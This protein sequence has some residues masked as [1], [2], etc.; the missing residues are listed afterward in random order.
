MVISP[1]H[2]A[3]RLLSSQHSQ[4]SGRA[5]AVAEQATSTRSSRTGQKT[6]RCQQNSVWHPRPCLH[7]CIIHAASRAVLDVIAISS[8]AP[9]SDACS[10]REMPG[11]VHLAADC[12]TSASMHAI[13]ADPTFATTA[14]CGVLAS[15]RPF[16]NLTYSPGG[17]AWRMLHSGRLSLCAP[18]GGQQALLSSTQLRCSFA[19]A[20]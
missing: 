7:T 1:S 5:K 9:S 4:R 13:A 18:N 2:Q 10:R 17:C 3:H 6:A 11:R 12:T 16:F 15:E 20:H 8:P 14:V 19:A